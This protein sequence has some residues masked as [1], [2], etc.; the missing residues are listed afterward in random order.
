MPCRTWP[1]PLRSDARRGGLGRSR[2]GAGT[3]LPR[4][5]GPDVLRRIAGR[6]QG[7][8]ERSRAALWRIGRPTCL[9]DTALS[10]LFG[11]V[12]GLLVT[13]VGALAGFPE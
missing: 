3:D 5:D 8:N 6:P 9:A 11:A 10:V 2:I 12:G 4:R 1:A 7:L 13:A